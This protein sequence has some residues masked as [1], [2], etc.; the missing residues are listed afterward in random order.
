MTVN[1]LEYDPANDQ[2]RRAHAR[3][4]GIRVLR[5][6]TAQSAR[7]TPSDAEALSRMEEAGAAAAY[8]QVIPMRAS[9][10]PPWVETRPLTRA[11]A[12]RILLLAEAAHHDLMGI[13]TS[14]PRMRT[15]FTASASYSRKRLKAFD[16]WVAST[17]GVARNVEKDIAQLREVVESPPGERWVWLM[18]LPPDAAL[19]RAWSPRARARARHHVWENSCAIYS[20]PNSAN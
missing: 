12:K 16:A 7:L 2:E 4:A 10:A 15:A 20:T 11:S 3:A 19:R 1:T 13:C 17:P 5:H 9:A 18:I 6:M 8:E 14:A